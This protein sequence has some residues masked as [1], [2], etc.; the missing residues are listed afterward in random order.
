[1][2]WVNKSVFFVYFHYCYHY[3]FLTDSWFFKG[4]YNFFFK[5][6]K[7]PCKW[8]GLNRKHNFKYNFELTLVGDWSFALKSLTILGNLVT[9]SLISRR[10]IVRNQTSS[11][12]KFN[13]VWE[14]ILNNK[15][16]KTTEH[17]EFIHDRHKIVTTSLQT[18]KREKKTQNQRSKG[19]TN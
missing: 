6:L 2:Y 15:K 1:M 16:N 4:H 10:Q 3:Y 11:V 5:F 9:F 18:K 14:K 12:A 7:F 17:Q 19:L 8:G 13:L